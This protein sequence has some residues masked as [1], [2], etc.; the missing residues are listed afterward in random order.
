[1]F[2]F[3]YQLHDLIVLTNNQVKYEVLIIGLEIARDMK[4]SDMIVI[5]DSQFVI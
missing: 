1:M 4:I 5:G 2:Q 3:T